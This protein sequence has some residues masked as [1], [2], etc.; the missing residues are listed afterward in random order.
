[1]CR[2]AI[3]SVVMVF[4]LLV[5]SFSALAFVFWLFFFAATFWGMCLAILLQRAAVLHGVARLAPLP[6]QGHLCSW[7]PPSQKSLEIFWGWCGKGW[8]GGWV[9][10][11]LATN[12]KHNKL[13]LQ[14]FEQHKKLQLQ[15]FE[16]LR[17]LDLCFYRF[18]RE[19][20]FQI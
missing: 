14:F 2:D 1:M 3:S 20:R 6:H 12:K 16:K 8:V 10:R 9:F 17:V 13:Q 4:C 15:F 7:D 18:L 5:F 19:T 11:A